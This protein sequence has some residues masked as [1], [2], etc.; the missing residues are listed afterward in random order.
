MRKLV[1]GI[2][3]VGYWVM[4][5]FL[6]L[7]LFA[8][9]TM[10]HQHP[11]GHHLLAP[12]LSPIGLFGIIPGVIGFY[13][14]YFIL[15]KAYVQHRKIL[16][17][18]F[19]GILFSLAAAIVAQAVV[20][21]TPTGRFVNWSVET[22]ITMGIFVSFI[23]FVNGILGFVIKACIAW[24][25]EI[26]KRAELDKRNYEME[27]ELMKAQIN[28]HF[29]FNTINNIDGLIQ[30]DPIKAS[31]YLN[32]L[33]DIMRFMLYETKTDKI[34]L[35]KELLYIEK[36]VELQKIR[37][38]NPNY[39]K[40][41]IKNDGSN[42]LIEPML[43]IPF[44]E[45][46]FKHVENKKTEDAIRINFNVENGKINFECKNYFDA[47]ADIKKEEGGLGNNLIKRRLDL[48]YANKY[49]LNVKRT[50]SIYKVQLII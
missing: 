24:L 41:D 37:T 20:Y 12:F 31:L 4:Y 32:K 45:N 13:S 14:F 15:F 7:L 34:P 26:Q 17:L 46:A 49:E 28:P 30:Q 38:T 18:F 9:A 11:F 50:E 22:C 19:T 33:S 1:A 39:V 47:K 16:W 25:D 42:I 27:L 3:H 36:Y 6:I 43:F 21:Y 29:L 10:Q 44:I 5:L 48:L 35:S 23:A 8:F 40:L 2:L